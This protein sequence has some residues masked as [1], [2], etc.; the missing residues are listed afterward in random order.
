MKHTA[1]PW[2]IR[3]QDIYDADGMYVAIWSGT[4]ANAE[5]IVRA[6]NCYEELVGA[7]STLVNHLEQGKTIF[8]M[9]G[10]SYEKAKQ[11]ITKAKKD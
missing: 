9:K 5:F 11:A 4:R 10:G 2:E 7:L 3:G 1:L 8:T 6:C